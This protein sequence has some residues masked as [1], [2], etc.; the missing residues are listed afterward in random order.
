MNPPLSTL[1]PLHFPPLSL[2]PR[3]LSPLGLGFLVFLLF[4]YFLFLPVKFIYIRRPMLSS[5]DIRSHSARLTVWT[6][7][8][9]PGT[10]TRNY[11]ILRCLIWVFAVF[12]WILFLF[13]LGTLLYYW[14]DLD[15]RNLG[16]FFLLFVAGLCE[17]CILCLY[18]YFHIIMGVC[19]SRLYCSL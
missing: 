7:R 8:D 13:Q 16:F 18:L 14:V 15:F 17:L 12:K 6:A 9:S 2:H 19:W 1:H 4:Y 11:S 5:V 10:P 3:F